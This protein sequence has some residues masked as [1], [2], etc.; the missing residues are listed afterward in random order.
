[1]RDIL[2]L[3]LLLFMLPSLLIS[4]PTHAGV[5]TSQTNEQYRI[6]AGDV[7]DVRVLNRPE[8]SRERVRVSR[9]G[10]IRLPLID[11]E[12]PAVGLTEGE[13]SKKIATHY[14]KRVSNAQVEVS[15]IER[16]SQ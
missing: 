7:L 4:A 13:L 14:L 6:S 1:M 10:I 9:Y 2:A 8:L 12:I 16:S 5:V 11:E 15:V 3:L